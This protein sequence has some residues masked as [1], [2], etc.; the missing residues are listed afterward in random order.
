MLADPEALAPDELVKHAQALNLDMTKFQRC[1]DDKATDDKVR[2]RVRIAASVNIFSTP[3][4]LVGVRKPGS[5]TVKALRMIEG[6]YPY[7]VFKA[8]IETLISARD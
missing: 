1:F 2:E 7:E 4:F 5:S 3:T 8:T 6:R